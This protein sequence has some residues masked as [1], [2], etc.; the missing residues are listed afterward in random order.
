MKTK[1]AF[2]MGLLLAAALLIFGAGGGTQ[3]IFN[4]ELWKVYDNGDTSKRLN[5]ELYGISTGTTRTIWMPD[6][7]VNLGEMGGGS[8]RWDQILNPNA[9]DEIDFAAHV[10]ELNVA[11]FRVGDGGANYVGFNGTPLVSFNGNADIDLPAD[12]VDN[13]DLN[14]GDIDYL[15]DEGAGI[16]EA[17]GAGWN[18]D[19]GP[20]EKDDVYDYLIN[21]DSDA[22]NSFTDET[23]YTNLLD[24]TAIFTDLNGDDIVDSDNYAPGSID[25]EHLADDIISGASAVGTFESGD[26]FLILETGVGLRQAD[27]DNLPAGGGGDSISIDSV[28]VT[29][30]DFQ[31]TGDIDFIDTS[32]VVTANINNNSVDSGHYVADS[33]DDDD[34]NWGSGSGP[35]DTD[36][37]PEGSNNLWM[38][39]E[40]VEDYVGGMLGGTETHISVTYE[41]GT[42]DI[43]FVVDPDSVAASISAGAY[44]DDSIQAGDIDT[45]NCGTNCTWDT[46]ND[47]IDI[48]DVFILNNTDD[49]TTGD[50]I[51]GGGMVTLGSATQDGT[52]V[53]YDDDAG[54]DAT[55]Q[56]DAAD[57][58]GTSV[59]WILPASN[60]TVG[61]VLEIASVVSNTLTLEW[62]DD[63][64]GAG[65]GD[66]VLVDTVSI[67][68]AA[69]VDLT[70]GTGVNITLNAGASPDTATFDFAASEISGGTTWDD[71]GEASV[72]W[73]WNLTAGDPAI[74]FGNGVVNISSGALQEGGVNILNNDE[75]DASSELLNIFDDEQGSG[76]IVFNT[77]PEFA[78][79]V[80]MG[81]TTAKCD[82]T[83]HDAGAIIFKDDGD[84]HQV[85][86]GPVSND[87][88]IL[89]VTGSLNVGGNVDTTTITAL[90]I[91]SGN[92]NAAGTVDMDYGDSSKTDH[93]F[94]TD[95]C[96][97][98]IDGGITVSAGLF[99]IGTGA[100]SNSSDSQVL[101]IRD[102]DD[103][104]AGNA[105]A[106]S[107]SSDISRS[108]TIGYN[109][110]DAQAD[111]EG[112]NGYDHYAGLQT[113]PYYASSGTMSNYYG[114]YD[115]LD[116]AAGTIT[117]AYS[118]Y[119][120]DTSGV[121][122]VTNR[123]G[124][125]IAELDHAGTINRAIHTAGDTPSYFGGKVTV[126]DDMDVAEDISFTS[127]ANIGVASIGLHSSN[128]V[129]LVGGTAGLKLTEDGLVGIT[130]E[131]GG[132]IVFPLQADPTTDGD[133]EF[134]VDTD[135]WGSGYDAY[136]FW[137]G[138]ASAYMVATTASDSPGDGQVPKWNTGGEITWE[139]DLQGAGGGDPVLVDT[140]PITDGSGVDLTSGTGVNITLNAGVSPDTATFDF[141]ATEI[142]GGTTWDDGGE[143][144]VIWQWNLTSGDPAITFGNGIVNIS[145]G[146]LQEGGVGVPNLDEIDWVGTAELAD[147]DWGDVDI[148]SGAATVQAMTV[149]DAG[150]GTYY[151]GFFTTDTGSNLAIYTDGG[152]SYA[153]ATA[154]LTATTFSGALSGN[155]TT[156]TTASAGDA[157]VDFFGAGV[158]AVTDT[159][160]CTDLEGT[161]LS[162]TTGVLNWAADSTDL[163]DTADLLYETELDDFSELQA[164]ISDKTLVNTA[165]GATWSG[166]HDFKSATVK[167]PARVIFAFNI[168]DIDDGMDDIKMPFP[169]AM[170]ITQVT[171]YV[172]AG[173]NVVGRLYEVDGDGDDGDAVGVEASDWTFT[174]GETEDT[175][176][177]NA[178]FDAGD[179]IQWDTTSVSGSV[180]GF[181]L[182]VWG[183]ET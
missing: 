32:N 7:D 133:G 81:T 174:T 26:K 65:G 22:D 10:I 129:Y 100:S 25:H 154:T 8:T 80:D 96:S 156:C 62:D 102:V 57:A 158:D 149:S 118:L 142:S 85:T 77:S 50:I 159:T 98:I 170:T 18:G 71:G 15:T 148:S 119:C 120:A 90:S 76:Y 144:S 126:E 145:S 55:L 183:Y 86:L 175:S 48:D 176:F 84:T 168:H 23:W 114:H 53:I 94:T 20:P 152:L 161:G 151:P 135:G 111:F 122:A 28:E 147:E 11:D 60:G 68:D 143:A 78:T 130:I 103:G 171:A 179:Y 3:Q 177:N 92:I 47:E 4:D 124:V 140:T 115:A 75:M 27:F 49:S 131:D 136:E 34:I 41:D 112:S 52:L 113:N 101:V 5:F 139:D 59:E 46:T 137:N 121:G 72:V 74:T 35:I 163:G 30:P 67:T 54:G 1:V 12:S 14:W 178:T 9:S 116:V 172:T 180:T 56:I 150:A 37:I 21:F 2:C 69:G 155:A 153:Q 97:V 173:T 146:A 51:V 134:A 73:S 66:P 128:Y 95:D 165:D 141:D 88:T 91:D 64:T 45:I 38:V 31:S 33:I 167:L 110:F 105:H 132:N 106:F 24:G 16:N 93:T 157:A 125:Y 63:D 61:Q 109:S 70:S 166:T 36:D 39:E 87:T 99:S 43:D 104:G 89:A 40:D 107:D 160:T 79:G 117:N 164:Q 138:S 6:N 58:M 127:S 123:Y 83:I 181:S 108:G 29:D 42:N 13:A 162:I 169:S 44:N 17:F 82:V 182:T 19:V